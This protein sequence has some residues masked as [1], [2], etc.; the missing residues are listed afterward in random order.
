MD[1]IDNQVDVGDSPL[2]DLPPTVNWE[3]TT[4]NWFWKG[5]PHEDGQMY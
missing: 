4:V 5:E 2:G 3:P 1:I